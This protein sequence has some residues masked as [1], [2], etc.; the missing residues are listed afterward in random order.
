MRIA[1]LIAAVLLSCRSEENMS[2]RENNT[3]RGAEV[4]SVSVSGGA[5]AYTFSVGVKSPDTGCEQ[6]ADWWE[7][8]SEDAQLIYRRILTHSHVT[9]QPFTRSGGPVTVDTGQIIIIRAHMNNLGYV[10][11]VCEALLKQASKSL[12]SLRALDFRWQYRNPSQVTAQIKLSP[13]PC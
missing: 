11:V 2:E 4:T 7:V 1:L 5:G 9:E 10:P 13:S 6:Y 8:L 12:K 3:F